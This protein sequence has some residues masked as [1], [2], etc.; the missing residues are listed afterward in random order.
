MATERRSHVGTAS[1]EQGDSAASR[2]AAIR[3]ELPVTEQ[4][5]SPT[6]KWNW[7]KGGSARQHL[8]A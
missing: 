2:I 3:Q 4:R 8:I 7:K 5:W 1:T 6:H